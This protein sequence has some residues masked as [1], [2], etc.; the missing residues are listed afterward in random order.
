[1]RLVRRMLTPALEWGLRPHES[2]MPRPRRA[3]R[4][5]AGLQASRLLATT[6]RRPGT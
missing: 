1:M 4:A 2:A 3:T 6:L 5:G